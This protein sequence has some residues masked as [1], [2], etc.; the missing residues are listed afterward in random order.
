[1]IWR[2]CINY[3]LHSVIM[4][5]GLVAVLVTNEASELRSAGLLP[6]YSAFAYADVCLSL[7]YMSFTLPW[8]FYVYFWLGRRDMG[9][10]KGLIA[11]HCAVVVA[12][13]V[14]L[15]TQTSPWC[16]LHAQACTHTHNAI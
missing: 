8:S 9:T 4:V 12:E 15:L 14:Y 13:L 1:M 10:N 7:G 16:C 5:V 3:L 2:Q 11:H 6:H